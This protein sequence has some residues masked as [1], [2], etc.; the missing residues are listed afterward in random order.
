MLR[1]EKIQA[2]N[3]RVFEKNRSWNLHIFLGFYRE[4]RREGGREEERV[5]KHCVVL[6]NQRKGK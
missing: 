5:G 1:E 3:L 6:E 2:V 4:L